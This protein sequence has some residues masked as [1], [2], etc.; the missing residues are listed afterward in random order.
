MK[1]IC[2]EMTYDEIC[3]KITLGGKRVEVSMQLY[4]PGLLSHS[5][6]EIK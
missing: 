6:V 1:S 3:F 2:N 5:R 4:W